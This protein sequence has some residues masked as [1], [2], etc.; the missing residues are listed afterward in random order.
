VYHAGKGTDVHWRAS[1]EPLDLGKLRWL[2]ERDFQVR[3][4]IRR[5]LESAGLDY[6]EIYY[7]DVY[8]PELTPEDRVE[9]VR[10]LFAWVGAPDPDDAICQRADAFRDPRQLK[11]DPAS[12][13]ERIPNAGAIQA[14]LGA[15]ETGHL[16]GPVPGGLSSAGPSA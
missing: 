7:E 12:T 4:R 8:G 13:Y 2:M 15:D 10:A 16:W 5:F 9:Q 14:T 11:L 1:F 3:T 6:R